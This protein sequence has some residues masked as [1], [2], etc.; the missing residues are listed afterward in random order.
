MQQ[1]YFLEVSYFGKNY[2]GSQSQ[3]N[4]RTIQSELEN[5]LQIYYRKEFSL[6]G[7]SRTDKGVHAIQNFY[8]VD[9]DICFSREQVYNINSILPSDISL[10]GIYRSSPAFHARFDAI[11]REYRYYIHTAKNPFL[12]GRSWYFPYKIS[13]ELLDEYAFTILKTVDFTSFSKKGTD[14][15]SS[16]CRIEKST[17][18]YEGNNIIFTVQA[19][20]FLRGMVRGLT[21]TM[22]QCSRKNLSPVSFNT[23][24]A[25]TNNLQADFSAPSHG[26]YLCSIHYGENVFQSI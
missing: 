4:A 7:A 18:A 2:H 22:L 8:H 13:F 12:K 17:W 5:A 19:N 10:T 16:I 1:R 14:V 24:V 15:K 21:A 9:T 11:S 23:I 20:R 26:L 6:V 3:I 25:G